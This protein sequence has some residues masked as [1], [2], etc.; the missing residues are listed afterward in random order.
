MEKKLLAVNMLLKDVKDSN[1]ID[2]VLWISQDNKY[3]FIINIFDNEWARLIEIDVLLES[4]QR[5]EI[6]IIDKDPIL[7]MVSEDE[8]SPK[9]KE[10]REKAW[11]IVYTI[12]SQIPEPKVYYINERKQL[13][14][15]L[16][17]I[18]KVSRNTIDN[19]LKKY[20]KGGL[21]PN[22]LLPNFYNCGLRGRERAM[23][24]V[25][26]GRPR[27][28]SSIL[29]EGINVD[30]ETKR[31]FRI[32]LDKFYYTKKKNTLTTT[33]EL[34][35]KEYFVEDYKIENGVK[36]PI[37]KSSNEVPSLAQFRYW[38]RKERSIKKEISSRFS[39]KIYEQN[40][41]RLLGN[42]SYEV[43]EMGPGYCY[44]V[45]ATVADVYLI[46]RYNR[47]WIIGRPIV[48]FVLDIFSR[49]IT[50]IHV[51]LTGPSWEA[52]SM[53]LANAATDKV[54]FCKEY[55]IDIDDEE[56]NVHHLPEAILADRGEL[57]S[58]NCE[59]LINSLNIKIMN[60]A[61]YRGDM[62]GI[63]EQYFRTT[64]LKVKPFLPG[65][66]D[67]DFKSRGG[68]DYRLDAKL[69]IYQ[70]T[71]III[72]SVLYHNNSS[73]INNYSSDELMITD[74]VESIPIKLWEWGIINRA[75]MLRTVNEDI[76]R[77]NL[78]P[79]GTAT[80]TAR[81]IKFKNMLYGSELALREKWFERAKISSWKVK[82]H[83]DSRLMD[84]I[85]I[86]SEDGKGFE[87]CF[88]LEHQDRYSQKTLEEIEY[89]ILKED[90]D[91]KVSEDSKIQA[92]VN[93]ISEIEAIVKGAVS[94]SKAS[95]AKEIS[96][97]KRIEEIRVNRKFE[98][99]FNRE[100][101]A[102]ELDKKQENDGQV[103]S[104]EK[105]KEGENELPDD[106]AILRKK[107]KE[108]LNGKNKG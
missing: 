46:S 96:K 26:R 40:H 57:L 60:T 33:Y 73:W 80:V 23:S 48:Y 6:E 2:R 29:G 50:G 53:A 68:K 17:V 91:E 9:E 35:L 58:K 78:M 65:F 77:L 106:I 92:K 7:R 66:I 79:T 90:L 39:L 70:F 38:F 71:Q 107:Q 85:Y 45:D 84:Y 61:S 67:V 52:L 25:K 37:V 41:R 8:M 103:V 27:K 83:F 34:M 93:M 12:F 63:V 94:A 30:D 44:Q 62:K 99:Q 100:N 89:L 105:M 31:I 74:E 75:G 4:L 104:I 3:A 10:I 55:G 14:K 88:L 102:F 95:E 51:G 108:R 15:E 49:M 1:K 87:K 36:I 72:R 54:A 64:N 24:K 97:K 20:F 101:E 82:I 11:K 86:K 47:N 69:D 13:V 18:Y 76:I 43:R 5:N 19:Y 59:T 28:L 21:T 42:S 32:A 22:A 56:W 98:K 16:T 81:G